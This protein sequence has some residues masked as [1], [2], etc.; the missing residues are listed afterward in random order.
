MT[1]LIASWGV[2]ASA[3]C[4]VS[5]LPMHYWRGRLLAVSLTSAVIAAVAL[6]L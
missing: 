6:T 1:D 5:A 4:L 3:A 2:S